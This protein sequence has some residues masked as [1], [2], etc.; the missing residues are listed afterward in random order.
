MFKLFDL[1]V[2]FDDHGVSCVW[3]QKV[4]HDSGVWRNSSLVP[5]C[6]VRRQDESR[7]GSG[8]SGTG[9]KFFERQSC[10]THISSRGIEGSLKF[11]RITKERYSVLSLKCLV[12]PLDGYFIAQLLNLRRHFVIVSLRF[13]DEMVRSVLNDRLKDFANLYL[14]FKAGLEIISLVLRV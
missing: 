10:G 8:K 9:Q 5:V 14:K 12:F 3:P 13:V 11:S 7:L 4:L 2:G 1:V 6:V